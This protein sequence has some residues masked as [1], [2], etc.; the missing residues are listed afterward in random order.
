MF[1]NFGY[2]GSESVVGVYRAISGRERKR[3]QVLRDLSWGTSAIFVNVP[4]FIVFYRLLSA[5]SH[6]RKTPD[7]HTTSQGKTYG[8]ARL[9]ND[10]DTKAK[11]LEKVVSIQF[12][13]H[14][15]FNNLEDPFQ[16][17]Y[18]ANHS[19]ETALHKAQS[20][21]LST[22]DTGKAAGLILLDLS[23]A[24]D[25]I[26][27]NRLIDRLQYENG[28]VDTALQWYK[29]YLI[30]LKQTAAVKGHQSES[31]PLRYGVPQGSVLGPTKYCSYTR[32]LGNMLRKYNIGR[33]M[34]ATDTQLY[35]PINVNNGDVQCAIDTLENCVCEQIIFFKLNDEKTELIIFSTK[36]TL[37]NLINLKVN[38]GDHE[39]SSKEHVRNLIFY[40][41]MSMEKHMN[42][43]IRIAYMYIY[44]IGRVRKYFKMEATKSLVHAFIYVAFGLCQWN[45]LRAT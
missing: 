33:H 42:S 24:F 3:T 2:V 36:R 32:P 26:D 45:T 17:A 31:T 37:R 35:V 8:R 41:S 19:T 22:L 6:T 43:I 12:D 4:R 40:S 1:V 11:I 34:Y 27:Q 39:V 38:I 16:S 14:I 15:S 20:D 13:E 10:V 5:T 30:G 23:A 9:F 28:I 29:S 44:N 18:R 7:R 21:I 25:T